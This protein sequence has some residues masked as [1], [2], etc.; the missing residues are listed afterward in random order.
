MNNQPFTDILL[1]NAEI[2]K[3]RA[4]LAAKQ[5]EYVTLDAE[6]KESLRLLRSMVNRVEE[7]NLLLAEAQNMLRKLR[8]EHE[9]GHDERH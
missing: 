8:I 6:F 5:S 4:A 9:G 7:Q 1:A 3:L 2:G